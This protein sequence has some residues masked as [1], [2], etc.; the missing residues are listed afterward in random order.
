MDTSRKIAKAI[1]IMTLPFIFSSCAS[2]GSRTLYNSF[3][4][5]YKSTI[6][7]IYITT[8]DQVN[9]DFYKAS[10]PEFYF[11]ELEKIFNTYNIEVIKSDSLIDFDKISA[12]NSF[13]LPGAITPDFILCSKITRMTAMGRTR[14]FS[15]EYKL[16]TPNDFKLIYHSKY[17]TTF[18]QTY[19]IVPGSGLPSEEQMIRDAIRLGL[20]NM[21][22]DILK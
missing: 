11:E 9:I 12:D 4:Q 1:V 16:L 15:V 14:D 8:P 5:N 18:G 22:K 7:K 6:S 21:E 3:D 20:N 13:K 10:T 19:V 2:L 17:S